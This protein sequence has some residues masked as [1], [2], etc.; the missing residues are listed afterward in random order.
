MMPMLPFQTP[1]EGQIS[2]CTL[3]TSSRDWKWWAA[4]TLAGHQDRGKT[5]GGGA[6]W[7]LYRH[8]LWTQLSIPPTHSPSGPGDA[9]RE[10]NRSTGGK[11]HSMLLLTYNTH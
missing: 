11:T 2:H 8:L 7:G 4:P 10:E 3:S 5:M 6:E 9:V 1:K